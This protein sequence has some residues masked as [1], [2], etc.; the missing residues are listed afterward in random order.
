MNKYEQH[1]QFTKNVIGWA[2]ARK[3]IPNSTPFAQAGKTLEEV[4]ELWQAKVKAD[5]SEIKD[6]IG[7]IAVTLIIGNYLHWTG[8]NAPF[9]DET[10]EFKY[11]YTQDP[12]SSGEYFREGIQQILDHTIKNEHQH[13]YRS[14]VRLCKGQRL[15]FNECCEL[16][17]DEIKDRKGE[18]KADGVF[19]K[20]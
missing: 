5:K 7:D 20:E 18:M 13:A 12:T 11:L 10:N 6:A 17:W 3:L 15:D 14:L 2:E 16:A 1:E 8:I 9:D 4:A 19:Y